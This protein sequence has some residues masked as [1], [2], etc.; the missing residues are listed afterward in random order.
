MISQSKGWIN[1]IRAKGCSRRLGYWRSGWT[2]SLKVSKWK[3]VHWD[4]MVVAGVDDLTGLYTRLNVR[5]QRPQFTHSQLRPYVPSCATYLQQCSLRLERSAGE[6]CCPRCSFCQC[7]HSLLVLISACFISSYINFE[8]ENRYRL[9]T[10]TD[11]FF[12]RRQC[13]FHYPSRGHF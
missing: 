3:L 13:P 1:T 10:S 7:P 5:Q 12:S 2:S 9:N 4:L 11:T 8:G 6:Y